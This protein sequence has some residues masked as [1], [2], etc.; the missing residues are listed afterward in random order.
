MM[1]F[2][3]LYL[4]GVIGLLHTTNIKAGL[5]TLETQSAILFFPLIFGTISFLGP[6][7]IKRNTITDI[8]TM[9]A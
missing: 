5:A 3:G 2:M 9:Q 4:I 7:F 6:L 1:V 8:K